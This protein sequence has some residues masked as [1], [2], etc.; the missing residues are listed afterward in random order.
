MTNY[1]KAYQHL[2]EFES[3]YQTYK[4]SDLTES[5]TRSKILDKIILEVLG[6]EEFD[7]NREGWVRVGY[8][9]YEIGTANFQFVVEAKK[10]LNS[11][12]LPKSGNEVK[13]QSI[14]KGNQDVIDQTRQYLFQRGLAY[15]VITNGSQFIICR[16]SNTSGLDWQDEKCIFFKDFDDLKT[17]FDKFYDLLSK[18]SVSKYGRLKILHTS[19]NGRTIVKD[20]PLKRKNQ[21]LVRN[22]ISQHL[23][24]IINQVFEEIYNTETLAGKKILEACY[25]Q[26]EDVKKYNSE[27]GNVFSDDPPTFDSRI[28]PVQNTIETQKQLRSNIFDGI[29]NLPDPIILIGTAGAGKT[30]FIKYFSE[31]LLSKKNKKNRPLIYLDFRLFTSQ[32]ISDTKF[33]YK[34]IIDQLENKYSEL[35][36]TKFNILKTIYQEDIAKKREGTWSRFIDNNRLEDAI[37]D[38]ID[39]RQKDPIRHLKAITDYLRFKC[40]KRI[41]VLF[42]NADQLNDD[43]QKEVF[44]LGNSIN[45]NLNSLVIISLR[46]GYFYKWRK[47]P[48]FNAYQSVV[49]HI[50][51]PPYKLVLQKRIEYVMKNFNFSEVDLESDNKVVKFREGNLQHLFK[52][53]YD[54]LFN[55]KHSD[56]MDFLEETSYPNT[57]EGLEL[58]KSFLLSGHSKITEYMSFNYGNGEGVPIW[59][60]FKS[61]ALESNYYYETQK[62]NVVNLFYPSKSNKNH[63]TKV[64]ILNYL[65]SKLSLSAKRRD[66]FSV[67]ELIDSFLMAG[68]TA[69]II[70]EE[71][72]VLFE[73]KLIST[74]EYIEDIEELT[75]IDSTSMISITSVGL[76][77][78]EKLVGHFYYLDLVLQD[79]PIYEDKYYQDLADNFPEC[80]EYGNRNLNDRKTITKKFLE[81]LSFEEKKDKKFKINFSDNII[82]FDVVEFINQ[83]L[84]K[85]FERL[86]K[87]IQ[88]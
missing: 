61:I 31:V 53:L 2:L 43:D 71:L 45:R 55:S 15:G 62:S 84:L 39:E 60:F 35:N 59:E 44:L 8:Y 51:A 11:F 19:N 9:D 29:S 3:S 38:Y 10:N 21:E 66:Y 58:F 50:T 76:Y 34:T 14:Y 36:L 7:I 47:K 82:M 25:V 30:T 72:Q 80:D 12:K 70:E 24:P 6:W 75:E 40:N 42:D 49:Y 20:Y 79:T 4:D 63:F 85:D 64:R 5:D 57:R 17:N 81:Y 37:A 68:Y 78:L 1:D 88:K 27:L 16:F 18:E 65:K 22:K 23:I 13:V 48:P 83:S 26:N 69:D 87:I 54:T 52:N 74:S 32:T 46:E 73:S 86:E 41:C 77:Y 56:V 28:I 67:S 33:I